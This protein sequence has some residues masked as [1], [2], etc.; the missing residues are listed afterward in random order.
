MFYT[1]AFNK[2][3][4]WLGGDLMF[5]CVFVMPVYASNMQPH[6]LGSYI[7]G[8]AGRVVLLTAVRVSYNLV[9]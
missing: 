4:N 2:K 5:I 3:G 7:S 1:V 9:N 6:P 8:G